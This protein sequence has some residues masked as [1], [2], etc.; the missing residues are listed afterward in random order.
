MNT[1]I[2]QAIRSLMPSNLCSRSQQ[3][4]L[5]NVF[6]YYW[7]IPMVSHFTN[8][9]VW[10]ILGHTFSWL[11]SGNSSTEGSITSLKPRTWKKTHFWEKTLPLSW[12]QNVSFFLTLE[13]RSPQTYFSTSLSFWNNCLKSY[14]VMSAALTLSIQVP[15]IKKKRYL[16]GKENNWLFVSYFWGREASLLINLRSTRSPDC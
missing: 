10:E 6:L 1:L 3:L 11:K 7:G 16:S 2:L 4:K 13:Q 9:R 15:I 12:K 5:K 8:D 14:D